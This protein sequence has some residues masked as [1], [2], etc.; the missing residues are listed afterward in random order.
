MS[1][2][3]LFF[4]SKVA[5]AIIGTLLIGGGAALMAS[6]SFSAAPNQSST[7]QSQNYVNASTSEDDTP[8]SA[9]TPTTSTAGTTP[10]STPTP[11]KSPTATPTRRPPTPTPT[12]GIG[13]ATSFTGTV[14]SVDTAASLFKVSSGGVT[15][16]VT[17][18][19]QT[20]FTGAC[21]AL[22]GMHTQW[23]VDVHGAYQA[24]G[25]FAATSVKSSLDD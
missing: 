12:P 14:I 10:S 15:K 7:N 25:T 21:T 13:Q 22:S 24:D 2:R 20:T 11:G 5:L 17:V 1:R 16:T 4:Q 8:S 3:I 19:S 23:W 18:T 6:A 9:T